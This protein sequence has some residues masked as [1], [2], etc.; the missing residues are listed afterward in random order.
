MR[1]AS[2]V[3]LLSLEVAANSRRADPNPQA[4]RWSS[5]VM[6]FLPLFNNVMISSSMGVANRA[7]MILAVIPSWARSRYAWRA[8]S[9]RLP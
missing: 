8:S 9:K 7:L 6:I 1:M 4:R 3:I 2:G 5:I